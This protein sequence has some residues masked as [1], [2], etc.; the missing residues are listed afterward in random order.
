MKHADA[1]TLEQ[2]AD[3]LTNVRQR[4]PPLKEKG[5]GVFYLKSTAFLHFHQDPKGIFADLKVQGEWER[6]PA[7]DRQEWD[8][9]LRSLD[10]QLM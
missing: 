8:V 7:N 4:I 10:E 6:F 9:L 1:Q 5:T 2:L 3:L